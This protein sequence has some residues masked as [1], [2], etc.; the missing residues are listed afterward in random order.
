MGVRINFFNHSFNLRFVVVS[1]FKRTASAMT[2]QL[3]SASLN[4]LATEGSDFN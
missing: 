3:A 1:F 4:V 2:K